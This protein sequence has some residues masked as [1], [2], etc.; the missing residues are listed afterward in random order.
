LGGIHFWIFQYLISI[1][2]WA[3]NYP[4]ARRRNICNRSNLMVVRI[5]N[6]PATPQMGDFSFKHYLV[7]LVIM[8]DRL[9]R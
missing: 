1:V 7:L 4:D 2:V 8:L 9:D 6:I 5:A 3:K